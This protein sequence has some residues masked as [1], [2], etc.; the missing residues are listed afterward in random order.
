[1]INDTVGEHP[2]HNYTIFYPPLCFVASACMQQPD[3]SPS[4]VYGDHQVSISE[5]HIEDRAQNDS[6]HPIKH[7]HSDNVSGLSSCAGCS[8]LR[9]HARNIGCH[10]QPLHALPNPF[11]VWPQ[12]T[13]CPYVFYVL[14]YLTWKGIQD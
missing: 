14:P 4:Q 6:S 9:P 13:C 2:F 3:D 5:W 1:M 12:E 11:L 10:G 8:L 7:F